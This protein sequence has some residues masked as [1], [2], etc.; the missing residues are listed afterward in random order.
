MINWKDPF[1]FEARR[2]AREALWEEQAKETRARNLKRAQETGTHCIKQVA[3]DRFFVLL[4]D[5]NG[6]YRAIQRD[7][8]V[9][10]QYPCNAHVIRTLEQA[11][12]F[13]RIAE[14]NFR[15]EVAEEVERLTSHENFYHPTEYEP[16]P[17]KEARAEDIVFVEAVSTCWSRR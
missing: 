4:R 1:G 2:L 10:G 6:R 16:V 11:K 12:D 17:A 3:A 14:R 15:E 13:G 5:T 9:A 7:G 8:K